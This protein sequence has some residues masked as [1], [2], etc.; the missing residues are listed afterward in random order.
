MSRTGAYTIEINEGEKG[1][2]CTDGDDGDEKHYSMNLTSSGASFWKDKPSVDQPYRLGSADFDS[3]L[4]EAS[5]VGDPNEE[6][7]Y[8]DESKV[9]VAGQLYRLERR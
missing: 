6:V 2:V 1:G 3:S 5:P 9:T 7:F 8:F 4:F